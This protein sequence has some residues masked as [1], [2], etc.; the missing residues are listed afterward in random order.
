MEDVK[1][2]DVKK[3]EF[4]STTAKRY[5]ESLKLVSASTAA[6]IRIPSMGASGL[7]T[8][9]GKMMEIAAAHSG[10]AQI[11]VGLNPR[12]RASAKEFNELSTG[13][14]YSKQDIAVIKN[15]LIDIDTHHPKGVPAS[16]EELLAAKYMADA[17]LEWFREK[18]FAK[19]TLSMS[20]NGWHI[21]AHIPAQD[22]ASFEPY[23]KAFGAH[24][25]FTFSHPKAEIDT[26]V[27]ESARITKLIGVKSI[28][29]SPTPD[30]P[31][32][33]SRVESWGEEAEDEKLL[34]FM[35]GLNPEQKSTVKVDTDY[36]QADVSKL[37]EIPA[38]TSTG[39]LVKAYAEGGVRGLQEQLDILEAAGADIPEK[40]RELLNNNDRSAMDAWAYWWL[41]QQEFSPEEIYAWCAGR[42][43]M[44]TKWASSL[45][46][47]KDIDRVY[48]NWLSNQK[49]NQPKM[50]TRDALMQAAADINI[51]KPESLAAAKEAIARAMT[52]LAGKTIPMNA[53]T[54]SD[55]AEAKATMLKAMKG[56]GVK[57][58]DLDA[59]IKLL[60]SKITS[61]AQVQT[62]GQTAATPILTIWADAPVAPNMVLP[63][64]FSV[65][66][67]QIL[68]TNGEYE[69]IV[70]NHPIVIVQERRDA[71]QYQYV[72][73]TK[74][75]GSWIHIPMGAEKLASSREL[76]KMA[77]YGLQVSDFNS[78][79]IIKYLN[80]FR[81]VNEAALP[82]Q[83][84][85][86]QN[87]YHR[88]D[89]ELVFVWGD[90]VISAKMLQTAIALAPYGPDEKE[91]VQYLRANGKI[92]KY[93]EIMERV[94]AGHPRVATI[95][96]S[97]L[98]QV[99]QPVLGGKARPFLVDIAGLSSQGKSV[100]AA[101][102][103][104]AWGYA[105]PPQQG[106]AA[107]SL[108]YSWDATPTAIQ[109]GA[110]LMNH[111][112]AVLDEA[113]A[114]SATRKNEV[115]PAEV[116]HR[117]VNGV[118]KARGAKEGGSLIGLSWHTPI[119]STSEFPLWQMSHHE[120]LK[121]RSVVIQNSPWEGG[122]DDPD[123]IK[124]IKDIE[125][126][127]FNDNTG[128]WGHTGAKLVEWVLLHPQEWESIRAKMAAYEEELAKFAG[129][130]AT[131][132]IVQ[133]IIQY[134]AQIATTGWL[135]HK[136]FSLSNPES[137]PIS[138]VKA[139]LKQHMT[140][141][142]F[143]AAQDPVQAG[144]D[145]LIQHILGRPG[146]LWQAEMAKEKGPQ[147]TPRTEWIGRYDPDTKK[148]YV[149]STKV[150]DIAR[151]IGRSWESLK[152][153][154][155]ERGMVV[156]GKGRITT[157]VHIG[158]MG[159]QNTITFDVSKQNDGEADV[160]S[161]DSFEDYP[162]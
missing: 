5:V 94:V 89:G 16:Q 88:V 99:L 137:L 14:A 73:A 106:T 135:V 154:F 11:Y 162:F 58:K 122:G 59:D 151:T 119:I 30:R 41:M 32:R 39:M 15:V 82:T 80:D 26:A 108:V 121:A 98:T 4:S 150:A 42:R 101:L 109:Y 51:S 34:K 77:Q 86:K 136:V 139:T 118:G 29:E 19:P 60:S 8:D 112:C 25:K 104:S 81:D 35:L 36:A 52:Q 63:P 155:V 79:D 134:Y 161:P 92:E 127:I 87:G 128:T 74:V 71:G 33:L 9:V 147:Y 72:I 117:L 18:E 141:E 56:L 158:T 115:T 111:M 40:P 21:V 46:I 159:T 49:A 105:Q 7:F 93:L 133:R 116:V 149:L 22:P 91:K 148:L 55:V 10:K 62:Q 76:L 120:G 90:T 107:N 31:N 146:D 38:R 126:N 57:A 124:L 65:D 17:V 53:A 37:R 152:D 102:A 70:S 103:L 23:L 114:K 96:Y 24:L 113:Q 2:E 129:D 28:K 145:A 12:K 48:Q 69:T 54:H 47:Q 110:H 83:N 97:A 20:G 157:K 64:G 153:A 13:K 68:R 44:G 144:Y 66:G 156:K 132:G 43:G 142:S 45:E 84:M 131:G 67:D 95:W 75:K 61:Q 138:N 160:S 143:T 140:T 85:V 3:E 100:S 50:I 125:Q 27:F 6:E 1:K 130:S 78:K 123:T